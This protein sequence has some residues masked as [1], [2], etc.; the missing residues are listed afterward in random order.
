MKVA[1]LIGHRYNAQGAY[2]PHL[3]TTEYKWNRGIASKLT[4]VADVY[5]RPDTIGV[6][7]G[8][9]IAE[10][11]KQINRKDYDLVISLHFNSHENKDANG[12]EALYYHKNKRME[13]LANEFNHLMNK[14]LGLRI[15]GAKPISSKRQNGGTFLLGCNADAILLE[16][17][18]GSN[19][20]DCYTI[21]GCENNYV[22]II[23]ELIDLHS[24]L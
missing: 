13:A 17:F 2:S 23:R 21:N 10:V 8:A 19:Q 6:S 1:I 5:Y 14:R 7:E 18:F 20:H 15:R 22:D 16:P 4:D 9:R 12:C 11:V 24:T 3:D